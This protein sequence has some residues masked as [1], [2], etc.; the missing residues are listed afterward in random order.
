MVIVLI[1]WSTLHKFITALKRHFLRQ[2]NSNLNKKRL[3]DEIKFS[4][5]L[6]WASDIRCSEWVVKCVMIL[7]RSIVIDDQTKSKSNCCQMMTVKFD[8][9][10]SWFSFTWKFYLIKMIHNILEATISNNTTW[11]QW[12]DALVIVYLG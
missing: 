10:N 2:C 8:L 12:N 1:Y 5:F 3:G 7:A 9:S 4:N 11:W 6:V